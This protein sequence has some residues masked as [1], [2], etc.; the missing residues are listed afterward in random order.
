M[1]KSSSAIHRGRATK[2]TAA[3]A[4]RG[5][6]LALLGYID[7]EIATAFGISESTLYN[8]K[9]AHLEF[10]EAIAGGREPIDVEAVQSLR[11]RMNGGL[12]EEQRAFKIRTADGGE[13]VKVVT[14]KKYVPPDTHALIYFLNN[15]CGDKWRTIKALEHAGPNAGSIQH[16]HDVVTSKGVQRALKELAEA[17]K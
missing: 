9:K 2:Y 15:R 12:F 1:A 11:S 17:L 14:V 10:A 6:D 8:W 7:A 3:H 4:Q 13:E 16:R 5:Y